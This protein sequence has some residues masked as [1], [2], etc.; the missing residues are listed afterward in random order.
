MDPDEEGF[1]SG[2]TKHPGLTP[3][4]R[5][6][7]PQARARDLVG[8]SLAVVLL[9]GLFL[10]FRFKPP[11]P[12]S[13]PVATHSPAGG[14]AIQVY[15]TA[16]QAADGKDRAHRLDAE[17]A[18]AIDQAQRSVDVAVYAF[19]L[20]SV[21]D[22]LLQAQMRGVEIRMVIESDNA[23]APEIQALLGAGIPIRQDMRPPL[24]HHKFVVIDGA[25]V[26]TGSMNMTVGAV[27][28]DDNN[29][30]RI[31]SVELAQAFTREFEEMFQEDR[32][33]ALSLE[34]TPHRRLSVAGVP[35]EVM[36]SPDDGAAERIIDL[37]DG[38]QTSL[39]FAAFSLTLNSIADHILSA[40]GRGVRVR[41]VVETS[42][43]IGSGSEYDNLRASGLDVRLDGNPFNM[44]HKF[45]IVDREIVVTGSYNFSLSAEERNDEN[46]VIIHDRGLAG[47]Y[48][49]EFVRL[50]EQA[51]ATN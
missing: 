22:A 31:A 51:D 8:P 44:H 42:Q 13:P 3:A 2:R 39:E 7:L 15:F 50:L 11:G 36:F 23:S 5:P 19:N 32:F 4:R 35:L 37:I 9:V 29:L 10:I 33:G 17:L 25:V 16:P 47:L 30:L 49:Q 26:W 40:M 38:S 48:L 14:E 34:D 45:L 24:M 1:E 28:H 27:S 43:A 21:A 12:S 6:D 18:L 20:K 41:G 46:L